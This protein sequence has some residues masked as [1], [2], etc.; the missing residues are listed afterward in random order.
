MVLSIKFYTRIFRNHCS[1]TPVYWVQHCY[2]MSG[3][4]SRHGRCNCTQGHW[5]FWIL[6]AQNVVHRKS[7]HGI[8][9]K[10]GFYATIWICGCRLLSILW[11]GFPKTPHVWGPM[12]FQKLKSRTCDNTTCPNLIVRST[13]RTGHRR[14]IG[15]TPQDGAP[16]SP[17]DDQYLIPDG[18]LSYVMG[19]DRKPTDWILK[20]PFQAPAGQPPPF[21]RIQT[22]A[23][24]QLHKK[25][26]GKPWDSQKTAPCVDN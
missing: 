24:S 4:R 11:L 9:K 13:G 18:F 26:M 7:P 14:I 21:P 16:R 17:L 1:I 19:W 3:P 8:P 12:Y 10:S 15:A 2:D 5:H 20:I 25:I 23:G 22:S 6:P